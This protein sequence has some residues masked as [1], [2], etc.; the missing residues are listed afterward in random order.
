MSDTVESFKRRIHKM[1]QDH[2]KALIS[3]QEFGSRVKQL[4][5][6]VADKTDYISAINTEM[7][8]FNAKVEEVLD[9]A[10]S[11][12][13]SSLA[14]ELKTLLKEHRKSVAKMQFSCGSV[15]RSFYG[16]AEVPQVENVFDVCCKEEDVV[17]SQQR[18][19]SNYLNNIRKLCGFKRTETKYDALEEK[20]PA[21][22]VKDMTNIIK[23][24]IFKLALDFYRK[25]HE[26][27]VSKDFEFFADIHSSENL[28]NYSALIRKSTR[29][30]SKLKSAAD[31]LECGESNLEFST[32]S[33]RILSAAKEE[34]S[35]SMRHSETM[36]KEL[37]DSVIA[38]EE[39]VQ[40]READLKARERKMRRRAKEELERSGKV[41]RERVE[42]KK[43]GNAGYG[44]CLIC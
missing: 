20:E 36:L 43:E 39:E 29:Q 17:V 11:H 34:F 1:N 15:S 3:A 18:E 38:K 14:G 26:L 44:I 9:A 28:T 6:E 10:E 42:G 12:T 25:M 32:K 13:G 19:L 24:D 7:D 30:F 2:E 5:A 16:G 33:E 21:R 22:Q 31:K 41:R 8:A 23:E 37:R 40:R 4:E 35:K 27:T